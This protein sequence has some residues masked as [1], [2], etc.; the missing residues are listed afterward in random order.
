MTMNIYYFTVSVGQ[1]LR[2][3]SLLLCAQWSMCMIP[4]T[5]AVILPPGGRPP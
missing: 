5:P 2:D 3:K 4:R 1:D